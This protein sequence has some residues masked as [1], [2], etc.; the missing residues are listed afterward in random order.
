L[1]REIPAGIAK[2]T[3]LLLL[4]RGATTKLERFL[5]QSTYPNLA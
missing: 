3:K 1:L 2:Y 4:Q 5:F